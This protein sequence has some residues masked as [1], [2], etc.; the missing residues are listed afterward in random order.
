M[1]GQLK[2]QRDKLKNNIVM[3]RESRKLI[4]S[5]CSQSVSMGYE[6]EIRYTDVYLADMLMIKLYSA[7]IINMLKTRI[8][9]TRTINASKF[10]VEYWAS[11]ISKALGN[12]KSAIKEDHTKLDWFPKE[13]QY[14]EKSFILINRY[15]LIDYGYDDMV[16]IQRIVNMFSYDEIKSAI[17][18]AEQ[19]KVYNIKYLSA[20]LDGE[21]AK[22]DIKHDRIKK[23]SAR[24]NQSN[25]LLNI[26]IKHHSALDMAMVQY[27]YNKMSENAML[28]K[29]MKEK[30]KQ[31]GK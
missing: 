12:N 5:L 28:D 20:I 16:K 13:W 25:N 27:N 15:L 23:L 31:L 7:P 1:P 26:D 4:D 6:F 17:G 10:T 2:Q 9:N 24:A 18:K 8:K 3:S 29:M 19:S 14:I 22:S 11:S 30:L 21:Q